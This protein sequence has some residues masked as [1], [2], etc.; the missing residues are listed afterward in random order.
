ME[1]YGNSIKESRPPWWLWL[2]VTIALAQAA[3][4]ENTVVTL[5]SNFA[6]LRA[7]V[8]AQYAALNQNVQLLLAQRESRNGR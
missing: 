3:W 6:S 7:T 8:T 5:E 2:I 4:I 1:G